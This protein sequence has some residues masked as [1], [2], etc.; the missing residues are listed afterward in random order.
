MRGKLLR[1]AKLSEILKLAKDN[2]YSGIIYI[3]NDDENQIVIRRGRI[4]VASYNDFQDIDALKEIAISGEEFDFN[5]QSSVYFKSDFEERT[6]EAIKAVEEA[7]E[8]F[9][10]L[11]YMMNKYI[12]VSEEGEQNTISLKREEIKFLMDHVSKPQNINSIIKEE[13]KPSIEVLKFLNQLKEKN[14]ITVYDVSHPRV[15]DY[16]LEHYPE[17]VPL[18]EQ[19]SNDIRAFEKEL[20]KNHRDIA[21]KIIR[22]ISPLQK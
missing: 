2:E 15:Y 22:E 17:I 5:M 18:F 3:G 13:K 4:V 11:A 7:E 8:A 6:E 14:L 10:K 9:E 1:D 20:T 12:K 19:Y 21:A 16:L